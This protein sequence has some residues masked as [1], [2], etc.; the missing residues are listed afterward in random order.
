MKKFVA[1]LTIALV[2]AMPLTAFAQAAPFDESKATAGTVLLFNADTGQEIFSKNPDDRIYPA[3]TTKLMTVLVAVENGILDEN[4][5]VGEEVTAFT[6]DSSLMGLRAG[7]S[8]PGADL[9]YGMLLC[10]GND[11]AA[12]TAVHVGGSIDGFA[13]LMNEKAVELGMTGSHFVNP[14]GVQDDR[15]YTTGADMKKLVEAVYKNEEIMEIAGAKT[16]TVQPT[17]M[18]TEPRELKNT[19][20]LVYTDPEKPQDAGCYYDYATGMKTGYT[21]AAHGCLVA[22]ASKDGLNLI[23]LIFDDPSELGTDRWG[24]AKDLFDYGFANYKNVSAADLMKDYTVTE[25]IENPA[26]ND[27]QAGVLKLLALPS[28]DQMIMLS[29]DQLA[30]LQSGTLSLNPT[31]NLTRP[32]SITGTVNEG[33]EFGTVEFILPNGTPLG[34]AKLVAS[35]DVY[36]LGDEKLQSQALGDTSIEFSDV[37]DTLSRNAA[38]LWWL[39]IPAGIIVFL[40]I[41]TMTASR[42]GGGHYRKAY[43]PHHAYYRR[44]NYRKMR[45]KGRFR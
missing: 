12:A 6:K 19:N 26:E 33:D 10:S 31:V 29:I 40:L 16:Y 9:V 7:E 28:D 1:I 13:D 27:P 35:R 24:M 45:Y 18:V 37:V 43:A 32:L 30:D 11:A 44:P 41:R 34:A 22:S 42:Q 39:L 17:D 5:K 23:T 8:I 38:V 14:H 20:K 15:H 25:T 4:V 2:L 21:A 36:K 3:S